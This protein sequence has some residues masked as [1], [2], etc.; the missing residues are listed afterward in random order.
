M[1]SFFYKAI[2]LHESNRIS[3]AAQ[4]IIYGLNFDKEKEF[5]FRY[6][7]ADFLFRVAVAPAN[8][9]EDTDKSITQLDQ[10]ISELNNAE[11]LLLQN[12]KE[13]ESVRK[14]I[15]QDLKDLCPT[16]LNSEDL[17]YQVRGLRTRIEMI[18]QSTILFK[19]MVQTEKRVNTAIEKNR[20]RIESERVRTIELLGIF[21]AIFAFI[22]SG[23]QIF[24]RLPLSEALVLQGGLALIMILFFLGIHL[25]TEPEAREK[26][27]IVIFIV[28]FVLLLGLPFYLKFLQSIL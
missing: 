27:L 15:S 24:T 19:A 21:T 10:A 18:R 11:L 23:V 25:V 6:L 17:T 8:T 3:D 22:F 2:W 14:S 5:Y 7:S 12:S 16:F 28:L 1:V 20:E 4:V 26:L 9:I 13:V